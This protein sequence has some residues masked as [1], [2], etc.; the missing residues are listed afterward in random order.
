M[1]RRGYVYI[2]ASKKNGTLYTGVTS[3]LA[4]RLE[5]HE[6]G[7]GSKFVALWRQAARMVRRVLLDHRCDC[8]REGH[9]E[10][11]SRLEDQADRREQSRLAGYF[12]PP[13]LTF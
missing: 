13:A 5:Q 9:Q 3:D 2:L 7:V 4:G 8:A 10:M 11:A 6:T 1:S 12:L